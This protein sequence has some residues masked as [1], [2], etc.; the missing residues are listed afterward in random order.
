MNNFYEAKMLFQR[1]SK[2]KRHQQTLERS[3][4]SHFDNLNT[5]DVVIENSKGE[6]RDAEINVFTK[7]SAKTHRPLPNHQRFFISLDEI[8]V[9]EK[10]YLYDKT[11]IVMTSSY[12]TSVYYEGFLI[13]CNVELEWLYEQWNEENESYQTLKATELAAVYDSNRIEGA[14]IFKEV[15]VPDSSKRIILS[16]NSLTDTI[17]RGETAFPIDGAMYRVIYIDNISQKGIRYL[18]GDEIQATPLEFDIVQPEPE[19]PEE[20]PTTRIIVGPD[21]IAYSETNSYR[22]ANY[23]YPINWTFIKGEEYVASTRKEGLRFYITLKSE[24]RMIG[25][26]IVIRGTTLGGITS[27]KTITITSVL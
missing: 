1:K 4:K 12:D 17:Q 16:N 10:V 7:R 19:E 15:S 5:R 6:T 18:I 21:D 14:E 22:M 9:G 2:K 3:V 11:W 20:A 23:S 8:R 24:G 27:T 13:Q 25:E 26:E